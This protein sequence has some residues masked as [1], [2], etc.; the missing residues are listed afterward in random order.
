MT[1][2]LEELLAAATPGPW[3]ADMA[4]VSTE[5]GSD[6]ASAY[7]EDWET[8]D[9][10]SALIALAPDAVRLLIEWAGD[11]PERLARLERLGESDAISDVLDRLAEAARLDRLGT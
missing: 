4:H 3:V 2:R 5:G 1:V 10:N 7:G 11:D 9:S 6:V 8:A